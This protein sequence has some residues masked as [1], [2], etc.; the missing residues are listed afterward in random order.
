[1]PWRWM[2]FQTAKSRQRSELG[3]GQ[4]KKKKRSL[5]LSNEKHQRRK[6]HDT[7]GTTTKKEVLAPNWFCWSPANSF[8]S[9]RHILNVLVDSIMIV[10]PFF[11]SLNNAGNVMSTLSGKKKAH[12]K[13]E[14]VPEMKEGDHSAGKTSGGWRF[15]RHEPHYVFVSC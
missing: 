11:F 1:M 7:N 4:K 13:C 2:S 12:S 9:L 3:Q 15:I 14:G 6:T 8:N 5:F 10:L